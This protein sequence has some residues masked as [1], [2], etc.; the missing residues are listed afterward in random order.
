MNKFEQKYQKFE[1][2]NQIFFSLIKIR[3]IRSIVASHGYDEHLDMLI[4]DKSKM[5]L[6]SVLDMGRDKDIKIIESS[7]I[8]I[9][10]FSLFLYF[11]L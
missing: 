11:N 8:A 7:P 9:K 5:V 2:K 1:E 3:K 4:N 10:L 6:Q